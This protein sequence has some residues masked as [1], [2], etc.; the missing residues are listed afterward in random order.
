M[1]HHDI[2]VRV[3]R[4]RV[5]GD[6]FGIWSAL[7]GGIVTV[8]ISIVR[9]CP[10]AKLGLIGRCIDLGNDVSCCTRV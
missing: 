3:V 1:G 9:K 5:L 2:D 6:G 8:F 7:V 10:A 4:D